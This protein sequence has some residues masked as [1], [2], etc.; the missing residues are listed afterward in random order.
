MP[1]RA[2]IMLKISGKRF[3]V[4]FLTTCFPQG[5]AALR[6]CWILFWWGFLFYCMSFLVDF[7]SREKRFPSTSLPPRATK[8]RQ[9]NLEAKL[10]L[11]DPT[12]GGAGCQNRGDAN[13]L[14]IPA[15]LW[16]FYVPVRR[17]RNGDRQTERSRPPALP[18]GW[19]ELAKKKSFRTKQQTSE[20]ANC[21]PERES[22][23]NDLPLDPVKKAEGTERKKVKL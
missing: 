9:T 16:G 20:E 18:R 11:A 6:F 3:W 19:C 15:L 17:D 13:G 14:G 10:P 21:S 12:A 22:E 8:P 2:P 1:F 5:W 23:K 4:V 7:S